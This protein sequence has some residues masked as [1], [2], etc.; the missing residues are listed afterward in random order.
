MEESESA[1]NLQ[2]LSNDN[3]DEAKA[4]EEREKQDFEKSL[5]DTIERGDVE[6]ITDRLNPRALT[7][8]KTN[9]LYMAMKASSALRGRA[10]RKGPDEEEFTKLANSVDEFSYSLLNP[11]KSNIELRHAFADSLADVMDAAIDMEQK[12]TLTHPVLYRLM[13][14]KWFGEFRTLERSSLLSLQYLKWFLLNIWCVFDVLFFPVLL[15]LFYIIHICRDKARKKR[16]VAIVFL[17][18]ATS[19]VAQDAFHIMKE[20]VK[21]IIRKYGNDRAEYHIII[22][23]PDDYSFQSH[24]ICFNNPHVN[25]KA[26][27]DAVEDLQR[28]DADVPALH[29]DLQKANEA[30]ESNKIKSDAEKILV[31]LTDH[32]TCLWDEQDQVMNQLTEV[33]AKQVKVITAA[34]G[35][36][37]NLRQLKDVNGGADVLHFQVEEKKSFKFFGKDLLHRVDGKDIYDSYRNYFTTPYFVF[38]RDTLSYQV[39][40]GL[41]FTIC[42]EASSISFT[43]V[44]WAILVF[45]MGRVLFEREQFSNNKDKETGKNKTR[46]CIRVRRNQSSEYLKEDV[47]TK[48]QELGTKQQ[49]LTVRFSKYIT[50]RWN[51]LDLI[52]LI[53][54][55]ATFAL[56][57]V[58]LAVSESVTDNRS[59]VIAG[60]FYGINTMFLTLRTIGHVME[61][62]K[63][64]GPIQ[65]A[66]F[67]IL[68][69]LVTIFWQFIATILAFSI[70]IT[71]VYVAEKSFISEDNGK[72]LVCNSSGIVCWWKMVR[73]LCWSL[74]GAVDV[75]LLESADDPSVMLVH[76]LYG[77]FLVMGAILLI[78]MMI[79]L[80]SNTYQK[81]QDNSLM[82]WSFKK[83]ITIQTYSSCDPIPVPVNF[84]SLMLK[85]CG[86]QKC[87]NWCRNRKQRTQT[88]RTNGLEVVVE[89][90]ESM[91]FAE[92][93]Y[94]FPLTEE[95]KLDRVLL[96]TERNRQMANQIAQRTFTASHSS[97]K[98]VLPTGPQAWDS[99]G[100]SVEECLLT[101]EGAKLCDLC[102]P[103]TTWNYH[104]ARYII[105]FSLEF[106]H[107]EVLIQETGDRRFLGIGAVWKGY[108]AGHSMPGWSKGTVGYHVDDGKIFHAKN[109]HKG[110]EVEDAM[111]YRGDLIGCTIKFEG[112]TNGQVPVVF[113]LNGRRITQDEI[114][115]DYTPGGKLMYPYIAMGHQGIRVLAK[116]RPSREIPD[117]QQSF[118]TIKKESG[119][120]GS[121]LELEQLVIAMA[122]NDVKEIKETVDADCKTFKKEV[123][124]IRNHLNNAKEESQALESKLSDSFK[125]VKKMFFFDDRRRD[126]PLFLP[127]DMPF[128]DEFSTGSQLDSR[129]I[130]RWESEVEEEERKVPIIV[131][132][133]RMIRRE[134]EDLGKKT[135]KK[136]DEMLEEL[137]QLK[138]EAQFQHL[139]LKSK[140]EGLDKNF[141]EIEELIQGCCTIKKIPL[142]TLV[143]SRD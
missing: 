138:N 4:K 39:L 1:I 14:N 71:K 73:H 108:G 34:F 43:W 110:K 82:E 47:E 123:E 38:I 132:L 85:C 23:H 74:M 94:L 89:R 31:I 67:H 24:E 98:N 59:L 125:R 54:Y 137:A 90:L 62:T 112:I 57:M 95:R 131:D 143:G 130:E 19:E 15:V 87:F 75:D 29:K 72:E 55:F 28:G 25:V 36:H 10:D 56:R 133:L 107:F 8:C 22:R 12:K 81:V 11:L 42:L 68:S 50:D 53:I 44:E 83:A 5:M 88:A 48:N 51:I 7:K 118:R 17:L 105:P 2:E 97:D 76:F 45:F 129:L 21:Y 96:E 52:T 111:A 139:S 119:S 126:G 46:H 141:L 127:R 32:R 109:P 120:R 80:L 106:P 121:D 124:E 99:K 84:V 101:C 58:T 86:W 78:N 64:I 77:A 30:F 40:L 115:I 3:Q 26:L 142:S 93:G 100:I 122:L 61:T 92:Y 69:D 134:L 116:M 18:N 35:P 49:S 136:T 135:K 13:S 27:I 16:D 37:A 41:H 70:A 9:T 102:K 104:G 140:N 60:Y 63:Q 20:S 33:K 128:H 65:I 113:T 114:W 6:E 79:A 117:E 66:L 103:G 91:Y